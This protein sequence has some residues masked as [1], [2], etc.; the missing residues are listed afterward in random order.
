MMINVQFIV[1]TIDYV[2]ILVILV[3]DAIL[4]H[5]Y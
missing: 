3:L 2:Q 4:C 1:K 5:I